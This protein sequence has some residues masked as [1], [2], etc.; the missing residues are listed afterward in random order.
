VFIMPSRTGG[1]ANTDSLTSPP[2]AE[3]TTNANPSTTD[4]VTYPVTSARIFTG[5]ESLVQRQGS[6]STTTNT[7]TTSVQDFVKAT[8]GDFVAKNKLQAGLGRRGWQLALKRALGTLQKGKIPLLLAV[9]A[10]NQ[11]M[12]RELLGQQAAEQ[13]KATTDS[14]DAAIHLAARRRDVDMIRILVD[15]GTN[16]D[17]QNVSTDFSINNSIGMMHG[18]GTAY[19]VRLLGAGWGGGAWGS[20]PG[21]CEIFRTGSHRPRGPRS[22]WYDGYWCA[23]P[24]VK[25]PGRG[26]PPTPM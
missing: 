22:L 14:G 24:G 26:V 1:R 5:E 23:F 18:T 4:T 15:Y 3:S 7:N 9:E 8:S 21:G 13:L 6:A 11:S 25:R 20:K 2:T 10:G 17:L 19:C 12:C 16:I